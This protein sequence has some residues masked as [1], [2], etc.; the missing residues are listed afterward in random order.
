MTAL[1]VA[2]YALRRHRAAQIAVLLGLSAVVTALGN[3]TQG[4][5]ALAALPI[6]AYSGARG[7]ACKGFFYLYYPAHIVALYLLACAL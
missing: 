2:F 4:W 7:R 1:G 5:M 3:P 6:A